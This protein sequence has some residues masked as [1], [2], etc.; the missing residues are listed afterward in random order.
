MDNVDF[1]V[2]TSVDE[3]TIEESDFDAILGTGKD[4]DQEE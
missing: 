3:M 2:P 4:E 1:F